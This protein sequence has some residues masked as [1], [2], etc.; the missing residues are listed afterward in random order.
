MREQIELINE[1]EDYGAEVAFVRVNGVSMKLYAVET[2]ECCNLCGSQENLL[3]P[4][5]PV[6]AIVVCRKCYDGAPKTEEG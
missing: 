6:P 5:E 2:N 3:A 1:G 4:F